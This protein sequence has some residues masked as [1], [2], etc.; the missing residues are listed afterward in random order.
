LTEK[1]G[2]R[3]DS[4][5][6]PYRAD[7]KLFSKVDRVPISAAPPLRRF[8]MAQSRFPRRFP[9]PDTAVMFR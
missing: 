7:S 8:A 6:S 5:P 4:P 1:R 3:K 9:G 2:A